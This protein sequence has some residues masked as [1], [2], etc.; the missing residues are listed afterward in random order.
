MFVCPLSS[1]HTVDSDRDNSYTSYVLAERATNIT[2]SAISSA[3]ERVG[4][5]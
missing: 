1:A 2:S 3:E 4:S 5:A